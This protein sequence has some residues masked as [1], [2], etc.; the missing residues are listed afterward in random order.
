M[1]RS[2]D[3]LSLQVH[4]EALDQFIEEN[5]KNPLV[6]TGKGFDFPFN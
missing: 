3:F 2:S 6:A 5:P 4:V 1:R